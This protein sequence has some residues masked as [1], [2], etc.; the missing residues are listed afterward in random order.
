MADPGPEAGWV[1][2]WAAAPQLTE[3]DNLP[4]HPFTR[5]GT[6]LR[7]STLRQTI[8]VTA[9]ATRIRLRLSN[10]F[11][12]T[13]L[14]I[15][16]VYL[17]R[18]G[19]GRAGVSAI[20]PGTSRAVTFAGRPGVTMPP[21]AAAVSDPVDF[22]VTAGANVAVTFYLPAGQPAA[23]GI[24][25]HPGSRTTSFLV[26]GDHVTAPELTGA[27]GPVLGNTG[28][29]NA[30]LSNTGPGSTGP[31]EVE[32][33]YFLTGV[34][35]AAGAAGPAG[36]AVF[37]GDSLTDGRGST[38]NGNDRWPDQLLDLMRSRGDGGAGS[39]SSVALLNQGIG[40]NRVL[41]DGLGPAILAR[42]HRD[43]LAVSGVRWLVVFA[44]VNDIGTAEATLAAQTRVV[45][46]LGA[47][48]E[49]IAAMVHAAG[50][51]CYAATLTPF[52]GSASYDDPGGQR[53]YA[54]RRVNARIR[55]RRRR[56]GAVLDF[57]AAV[58]DS[59]AADRDP[60]APR[61]LRAEFDSGDGL[62]L[63]TAG[64]RALANA[65]PFGLFT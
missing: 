33:W 2:I 6:V 63:N 8:R 55:S 59:G 57:E 41:R 28:L 7:D 31:A 1:G 58:V 39:A 26:A 5:D 15:A 38:T 37:L 25:S 23:G 43:V 9:D 11:G 65:V 10:A 19:G 32:H 34:D 49:Q 29:S 61:R 27:G 14:G 56:Y 42:L 36:A 40:G 47:A 12:G 35:A 46:E 16:R 50:I 17:A 20:E 44:G 24:T 4:P 60:L 13:G 45:T 54:R 62:H 64:Y 51:A 18:P 48:Y 52:G 30:G 53:E 22:P 21:G 3:P